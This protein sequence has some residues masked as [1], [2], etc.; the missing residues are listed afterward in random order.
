MKSIGYTAT[1]GAPGVA[2]KVNDK[3]LFT[4]VLSDLVYG[5]RQ[6]MERHMLRARQLG[7][8]HPKSGKR[9]EFTSP[10]PADFRKLGI[11]LTA[12]LPD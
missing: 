7:F 6:G 5:R 9:L 4:Y 8:T 11:A 12:P 2:G 10:L 1:G 3:T